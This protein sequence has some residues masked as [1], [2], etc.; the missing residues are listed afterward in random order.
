MS[1]LQS[2]LLSGAHFSHNMKKGGEERAKGA[3]NQTSM[4]L[5]FNQVLVA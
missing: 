5:S 1:Y 2:W 3:E 4:P